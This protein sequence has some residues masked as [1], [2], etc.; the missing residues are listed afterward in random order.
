MEHWYR[1]SWDNASELIAKL[2]VAL[3]SI[4]R[5]LIPGGK[6]YCDV[7]IHS[8]GGCIFREGAIVDICDLFSRVFVDMRVEDRRRYFEPLEVVNHLEGHPP[9]YILTITAT[10]GADNAD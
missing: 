4:R 2:E 5:V 6:F 8:H 3:R 9:A 10:K 7:P 1:E